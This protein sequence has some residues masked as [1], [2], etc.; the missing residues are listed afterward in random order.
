MTSTTESDIQANGAATDRDGG[1]TADGTKP[2]LPVTEDSAG[3][4]G[5]HPRH[6]DRLKSA[7][8]CDEVIAA[9]GYRTMQRTNTDAGP[10]S[11]LKRLGFASGAWKEDRRFPG[12]LIPLWGPT[13]QVSSHQYRPDWPRTDDKGKTRKYEMPKGRAAVLD[14]HP[15]NRDRIADPTVRLWITE[16]IKKGDALTSRGECVVTLSGVFNWRSTLGTLGDWEDVPL[17]GR[18]VLV[19]FDADAATNRHVARAM[20]RLGRWL[21]SKQAKAKYIVCPQVNGDSRTGADDYL[22]AGGTIEQ[23]LGAVTSAPPDPDAGDDSLTD[24]RLAELVVD[25]VLAGSYRYVAET[26]TWLGW[27]GRIWS[28][29]PGEEITERVRQ[30]LRDMLAEAVDERVAVDRQRA[31]VGLQS[32]SRIVAVAALCRGLDDVLT[33]VLDFDEDP[34]LLCA[35]NGVVDLRTGELHPHDPDLLM[36][37]GTTVDY[38][39]G[40]AHPDWEATVACLDEGPRAWVQ[41]VLGTG[42]TGKPPATDISMLFYGLGANG[43]TLLVGGIAAALGDYSGTVMDSVLLSERE[44]SHPTEKMDLMGLRLA[45]LEELPEGHHLNVKNLKKVVGTPT[46]K[47]RSIGGDPV[48]FPASH[49]LIMT[50]NYRPRVVEN[51]DG[52]WRRLALVRFPYQ[53]VSEPKSARQRKIDVGLRD[54]VLHGRDQR[55][56]A[57][58]WVVE[59]ARLAAAE[60]IGTPPVETVADTEDWRAGGDTLWRF[61]T[62]TFAFD[63]NARVATVVLTEAYNRWLTTRNHREVTERTVM[64]SL[65]GHPRLD[66]VVGKGARSRGPFSVPGDSDKTHYANPVA[67]VTGLRFVSGEG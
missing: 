6:H 48:E 20:A 60:G 50:S 26:R 22:A 33:S 37:R 51:D 39:S 59:G 40:A 32:R 61:V 53:Y 58:A 64:E 21:R 10:R 49:T 45:V 23:L 9:R 2:S 65:L 52:T 31:I 27:D 16:G 44:T 35:G 28:P 1:D 7:G 18:E 38:V 36:T 3:V 42:A 5:L 54:R 43:K 67:C 66:G 46:L 55:R 12:V 15:H 8:I 19:L 25:E 4:P 57:L 56:A 41:K 24:S 17:R 63:A 29:R 30:F 47:A 62:D 34:W 14:V 13:G 11:I